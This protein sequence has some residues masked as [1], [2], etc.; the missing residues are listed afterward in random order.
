LFDFGHLLRRK[1]KFHAFGGEPGFAGHAQ[2]G[3]QH[4]DEEFG[5]G[6]AAGDQESLLTVFSR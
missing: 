5:A 3:L 6:R 1:G 4:L 2:F